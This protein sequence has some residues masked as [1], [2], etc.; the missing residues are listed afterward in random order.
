MQKAYIAEWGR[1]G[2]HPG[3]AA[4]CNKAVGLWRIRRQFDRERHCRQS[5]ERYFSRGPDLGGDG[6]GIFGFVAARAGRIRGDAGGSA[7]RSSGANGECTRAERGQRDF[8]RLRNGRGGEPPASRERYAAGCRLQQQCIR[9]R[10]CCA[11]HH[12]AFAGGRG[13]CVGGSGRASGSRF[14]WGIYAI[15]GGNGWSSHD[16]AGASVSKSRA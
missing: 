5:R 1:G 4:E 7:G 14:G 12:R 8:G 13:E 15:L 2:W 10:E 11:S 9:G 3:W 6:G 16:F